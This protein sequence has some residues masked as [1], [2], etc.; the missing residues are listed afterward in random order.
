MNRR[1]FFGLVAGALACSG[2]KA[3]ETEIVPYPDGEGF[4]QIAD[5]IEEQL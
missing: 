4:N 1:N 5:L 3:K 2:I